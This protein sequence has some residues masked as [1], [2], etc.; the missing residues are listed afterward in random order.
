MRR[1]GGES[2]NQT[3]TGMN[4]SYELPMHPTLIQDTAS[5]PKHSMHAYFTCWPTMYHTCM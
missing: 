4:G 5:T 2:A 3:I 1:D